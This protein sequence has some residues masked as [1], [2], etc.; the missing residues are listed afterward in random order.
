MDGNG[1]PGSGGAPAF[2]RYQLLSKSK[3]IS[4]PYE[5]MWKNLLLFSEGRLGDLHLTP[6]HASN[7]TKENLV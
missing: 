2:V 5:M 7:P 3:L 6:C 1:F 4:V